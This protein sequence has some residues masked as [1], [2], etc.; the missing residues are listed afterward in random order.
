MNPDQFTLS[1]LKLNVGDSH[2]LYVQEWGS[3]NGKTIVFLHGGPGSG[4]SDS[5]KALFNPQKDRVIFFD[6]RGAGKSTPSGSLK[7][8][9]TQDLVEDIEKIAEHFS[10]TDFVLVGGSWGST[11]ALAY[12]LQYPM[13]VKAMVL[14]GLF[15]GSQE[16]IDFLDKGKFKAFFPDVWEDFVKRAPEKYRDDPSAYHSRQA[17]SENKTRR[18]SSLFAYSQME[19]N[20][21]GLDDR[22]RIVGEEGFEPAGTEIELHYMQ[23]RCFMPDDFLLDNA[24]KLNMPVWL[25]Q[26]RYDMVCPPITA[27]RLSKTLPNNKLIWTV[28]GH[29]GS[30]RANFDV[31][32]TIIA[33][34]S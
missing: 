24:H 4:C 22:A 32:K 5:H 33:G 11:L 12:A 3:A 27:Y 28:A 10:L 23:N 25:V 20:L 19:T 6:Q 2:K 13:R 21:I 18:M 9:T 15:T 29:S 26:G 17:F 16:E 8:N 1:E 14:R 34:L 31:V 7:N 30:D